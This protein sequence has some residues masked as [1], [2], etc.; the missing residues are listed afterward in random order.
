[1]RDVFR[2]ANLSPGAVY[3]YFASKEDLLV[4]V[5]AASPGIADA[6]LA[7][8]EM[9]ED[10]ARR[11]RRLLDASATGSPAARLQLELQ[12]AALRSPRIAAALR[13]RRI[14]DRLALA[15]ALRGPAGAPPPEAVDLVLAICEGKFIKDIS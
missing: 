10:P 12:A 8:A 14:D 3:R 9:S 1:M 5:A 13:E 2:A 15:E 4:A 7:K 6:A 11:L